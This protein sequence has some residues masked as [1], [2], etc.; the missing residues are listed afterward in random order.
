MKIQLNGQPHEI[1]NPMP[2]ADLLDSL[3]FGGRPVVV[4]LDESAV[5][6]RDYPTTQVTDGSRVEIVALAAGG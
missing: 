5:F 1:G 2:I 6:P 3:G 4:E